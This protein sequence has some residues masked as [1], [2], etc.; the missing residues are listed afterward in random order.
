MIQRLVDI[1]D[2]GP[3][4]DARRDVILRLLDTCDRMLT[5]G[6]PAP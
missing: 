2:R 4:D 3:L 6:S 1:L 5:N